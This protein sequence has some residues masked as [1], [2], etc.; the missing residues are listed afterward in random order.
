MNSL[1][2]TCMA[3]IVAIAEAMKEAGIKRLR[4]GSLELHLAEPKQ[5]PI[6]WPI[7]DGDNGKSDED[8]RFA[9]SGM[10]PAD[11]KAFYAKHGG[12]RVGE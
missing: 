12:K 5:E 3:D 8:F 2:A 11:L 4:H 9:A 7:H 6:Q 1:K 10:K